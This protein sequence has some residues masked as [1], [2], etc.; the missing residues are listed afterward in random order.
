MVQ[1]MLVNFDLAHL[2]LPPIASRQSG[3]PRTG[4]EVEDANVA[5]WLCCNITLYKLLST[6]DQ[7]FTN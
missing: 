7:Y 5:F 2:C 4:S 6:K 3:P 1:E